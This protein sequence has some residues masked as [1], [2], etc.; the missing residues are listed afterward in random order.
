MKQ[1]ILE[2]PQKI[3][4]REV[5]KPVISDREVLIEVQRIGIC[6]SDIKAYY[7]KHP[8]I[9]C[10]IVQG[11]E[12][13]GVV[14]AR[15]RK[16][17]GL[18]INDKVT[19]RP[20]IV[21]GHCYPCKRGDYNIC[22]NLKVIG[23]QAEGAAQEYL[24]VDKNLVVKLP[25]KMSF[26]EGAMVEPVAVAVHALGKA[27]RVRGRKILVLGAGTIGN[28]TAQVA[29]ALGAR[30]VMITDLSSY[31]LKIA[32]ECRIDH[33]VDVSKTNL[34]EQL[35]KSFGPAGADLILECVGAGSTINQA[36]EV[37]RKGSEIIVVGVF[38]EKPGIDIGL[39]QDKEL[40]LLGS[41]MY[42]AEDYQT[43]IRLIS[44]RKIRL[45]PLMS[46]TFSFEDYPEAYHFLE[47]S[48][49]RVMKV[50]IKF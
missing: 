13:S 16:V 35:E 23:C 6:G 48:G 17:T 38:D 22:Q 29:R 39:V 26:E 9:K 7:G 41:L 21:C 8:Y 32:R 44:S 33:M 1:A 46:R 18:R 50:F 37:A 43:A 25:E 11:H 19:V 31:R 40:K 36:I 20:Q 34:F 10:P 45:K 5:D 27:S 28:L 47:K 49:D 4:F 24:K 42:K 15:G 14:A 3:I 2:Q 30:S 12:F